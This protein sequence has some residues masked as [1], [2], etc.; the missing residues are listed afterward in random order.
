MD[1]CIKRTAGLL[2]EVVSAI[3]SG[4]FV[5]TRSP[6][7]RKR[8][9]D[10]RVAIEN[11]GLMDKNVNVSA[12]IK[13][14]KWSAVDLP[15][16][17][18]RLIQFRSPQYTLEV[19]RR[20]APFED[21]LWK[22]ERC[23][24]KIFAKGM[25]TFQMAEELLKHWQSLSDPIGI[26]T[27]YS[28][29]DSCILTEWIQAE[30]AIYKRFIDDDLVGELMDKQLKNR[31]YTRNGIRY[32][33]EGRKMSGEYNTSCGDSL[34]NLM[35]TDYAFGCVNIDPDMELVPF[36]NGDDNVNIISKTGVEE[37]KL[38]EGLKI[39]MARAGFDV[40]I[41]CV[42]EFE[43]ISFCQ[44]S[45]IQV[46]PGM[47]RMVRNPRRA[48]SRGCYSVRKY[49]GKAW[50]RLLASM[51]KCEAVLG[52]GVPIM[53]AWARYL[54]RAS[55]GAKGLSVEIEYRAA[56]EMKTREVEPLVGIHSVARDSVWKA[57]AIP[58]DDQVAIE[59]WLDAQ[60]DVELSLIHI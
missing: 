4:E 40:K 29:F 12:F 17:V 11:H 33:C 51:A 48:I 30:A 10:A 5:R 20:L 28:K 31:G 24:M 15:V 37:N 57:F 8:Y 25:N 13:I 42:N 36:I 19:G 18:P 1:D 6:R 47:W 38:V 23:G 35:V 32:T 21:I 39:A 52:D 14:E 58:P 22:T 45:P 44:H 2:D 56:L 54:Q 55:R 7:K 27:D 41:D 43:K 53:S 50:L 9:H 49:G 16:K 26:C 34:V 46:R 3:D 60:T 59:A